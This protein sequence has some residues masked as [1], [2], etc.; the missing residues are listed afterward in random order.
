MFR[1][2]CLMLILLFMTS[3]CSTQRDRNLGEITRILN[4]HYL[5]GLQESYWEIP[6]SNWVEGFAELERLVRVDGA[7]VVCEGLIEKANSSDPK[8]T[9]WCSELILEI[10]S[11]GWL[12]DGDSRTKAIDEVIR[13]AL[14]MDIEPRRLLI[15]AALTNT[16]LTMSQKETIR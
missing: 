2:P 9:Y 7:T 1:I 15:K 6:R 8:F 10:D 11:A 4:K 16:R 3:A 13:N 5:I 12:A 14:R